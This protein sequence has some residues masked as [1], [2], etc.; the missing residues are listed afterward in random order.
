MLFRMATAALILAAALP[1]GAVAQAVFQPFG[2]P[3]PITSNGHTEALGPVHLALKLGSTL[4]D[5][6]II[7]VSP[8]R[9]TNTAATD[10]RVT[11]A[12]S[13]TTG[14]VTIEAADGRVKVP[15]N[16]G[17]SSGS[18]R[19]EGIRISTVGSTASTVTAKVSWGNRANFFEGS[20]VVTVANEVLRGLSADT[21]TDIFRVYANTVVDS[22]ATIIL[23]EGYASSFKNS[24]DFGQDTPTRVRIRVTDFPK[25]L[26]LTFPASVTAVENA[27]TL[28]T[29]EGTA[30]TL[31]RS[32]G[33]TDVFYSFTGV[34]NSSQVL[35]SFK[36]AF[37]AATSGTVEQLQPTIG[38]TLAPI[39]LAV[40]TTQ[41]PAA[42]I[43]RFAE[44]PIYVLDGTSRIVT[45]TLYWTAIDGTRSNVL[46]IFNPSSSA[47]NL[48]ITALEGNGTI[49]STVRQSLGAGQSSS[50]SLAS[51]FGTV[52]RDITTLQI[53]STARDIVAVGKASLSSAQ[54]DTIALVDR[55]VPEF[56]LPANGFFTRFSFFNPMTTTVTGTIT[57]RS[58]GGS[59][60]GTRNITVGPM[61]TVSDS[62]IELFGTAS[63]FNLVGAFATPV[64]AVETFANA[65]VME[66]AVAQPPAGIGSLY[67][68]FFV[69]GNGYETEL[70]L[71]NQASETAVLT[72]TLVDDAGTSQSKTISLAPGQQFLGKGSETFGRSSFT[73]GFIRVDVQSIPRALWTYYPAVTAHARIRFSDKASTVLAV[74]T[75]PQSD[76][77]ILDSGT[78]S[79]EFQGIALINPTE[80][81]ATVT[82]QAIGSNGTVL[83]TATLT[84]EPG[85]AISRLT[86]ELF[87]TS[88][89]E[90]SVIRVQ[91]G[92]GIVTT[93]I[94]G[95]L[96][97]DAMRSTRGLRN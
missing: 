56:V 83:R 68:P 76:A 6:L 40:P 35:E 5:T 51:L 4:A 33:T 55:G 24:A 62:G 74:S 37:T 8:Y 82:L 31:P 16:A 9:V 59:V 41:V 32:D 12:G 10:I 79:S 75:Y 46:L 94:T 85:R 14:A 53:Q 86:T 13:V 11:T 91:S 88:I 97:G 44:D 43:P 84:L 63:G 1:Q 71:I 66:S 47:A 7:D 19:V 30:I 23:R 18:I 17:G 15:V 95:T 27:A 26:T 2:F 25:G 29:V 21:M 45:K 3:N 34:S 69:T 58:E 96:N 64:V 39:G 93:S 73:T 77:F 57:L 89:P 67:V 49:R 36:I 78:A 90:G 61:M 87:S 52:S 60:L 20:E 70:S 42:N 28:T 50:Q 72:A 22:T 54:T 80:T 65:E 38:L 48:T 81:T 92:V